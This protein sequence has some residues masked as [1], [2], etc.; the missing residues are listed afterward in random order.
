MT[1][2]V[3][4]LGNLRTQAIHIKSGSQIETDAPTDNHGRGS[5]FSPTDS[6]ATSLATCMITVMGIRAA[7]DN[8]PF[9]SIEAEVK[10][11]MTSGPR[12]IAEIHVRLTVDEKWSAEQ[13]AIMEQTALDCPVALSLHPDIKQEVSFNYK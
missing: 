12:R 5:R 8:I 1:S 2:H 7:K 9:E 10:K 11:V 6:T 4:Y 13:I 3:K